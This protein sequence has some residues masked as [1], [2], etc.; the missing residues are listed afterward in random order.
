[1][2]LNESR[3]VGRLGG[4]TMR[5]TRAKARVGSVHKL[6]TQKASAWMSLTYPV[7]FCGLPGS[8][9]GEHLSPH[10]VFRK[11]IIDAACVKLL[12]RRALAR[13]VPAS[14]PSRDRFRPALQ[15]NALSRC[16]TRLNLSLTSKIATL[17]Q[18]V[19]PAPAGCLAKRFGNDLPANGRHL[20]CLL[21]GR[22]GQGE[23]AQYG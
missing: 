16:N 1:M 2:S 22:L 15:V 6:P 11:M 19:R 13:Q 8:A 14:R 3:T 9:S 12:Q 18:I 4:A 23:I 10:R 20:A 5:F 7:S 21:S 17:Y